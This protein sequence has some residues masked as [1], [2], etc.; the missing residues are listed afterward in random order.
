MK[1]N[2]ENILMSQL[3]LTYGQSRKLVLEARQ[4]LG[5]SKYAEWTPALEQECIRSYEATSSCKVKYSPTTVGVPVQGNMPVKKQQ[6]A[7]QSF[8]PAAHQKPESS[9]DWKPATRSPAASLSVPKKQE[10]ASKDFPEKGSAHKSA[11]NKTAVEESISAVKRKEESKPPGSAKE[12][13]VKKAEDEP[14]PVVAKSSKTKEES[15]KEAPEEKVSA[16]GEE[17]GHTKEDAQE[18]PQ[19]PTEDPQTT[20]EEPAVTGEET[21]QKSDTV[22]GDEAVDEPQQE[23]VS[24][25]KEEDGTSKV[26]QTKEDQH[27]D[28]Q[29]SEA[30]KDEPR[31]DPMETQ[32][33]AVMESGEASTEAPPQTDAC[34]DTEQEEVPQPS[35]EKPKEENLPAS[36]TASVTD[37]DSKGS[38]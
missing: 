1:P 31:E 12:N 32:K 16:E 10:V 7:T 36:D 21:A 13:E 28:N 18:S 15:S 38:L 17:T 5:M 25:Q 3:S 24:V 30:S 4:S 8:V 11:T 27:G 33:E 9:K 29:E 34:G 14:Q 19:K 2:L 26:E 6:P 23:G 35:M 22:N 20:N 37:D